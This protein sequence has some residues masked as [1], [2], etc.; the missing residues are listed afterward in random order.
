MY[1]LSFSKKWSSRHG[2]FFS[3]NRLYCNGGWTPIIK[4][5]QRYSS[6]LG[7]FRKTPSRVLSDSL[8]DTCTIPT[9]HG[10]D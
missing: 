10:T 7:Y 9:N 6:W 1:W 2:V 4:V 5:T 8:D 3:A